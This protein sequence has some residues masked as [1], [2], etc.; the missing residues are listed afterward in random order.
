MDISKEDFRFEENQDNETEQIVT[1]TMSYLK[2]T[3]KRFVSNKVALT[4]LVILSIVIFFCIFGPVI[5][6]YD[7]EEINM[8]IKNQAPDA[9][10]W[11]GTDQLGRDLFARVWRGGRVSIMIGVFGALITAVVGCVY[12]GISAY[13]GGVVDMVMMRIVEIISSVPNLLV[14][15]LICMVFDSKGIGT[16]MFAMLVTGWCGLA[17]LVRSQMLQISS[18]EY[19]LAA[20]QM[21][22]SSMKIVLSHLIPNCMSTIIVNLTFR[23]PGLIFNEAFL[24]YIGLGVQS[25]DTSWGA[26]ASAASSV[27]M[28]HPYQL[29]FPTFMIAIVMLSFILIGDGLRDAMDPKL[30]R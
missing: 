18:S 10:H 25:P 8:S 16:L 9:Q 22:V 28:F 13:F 11:F 26:L 30:W 2:V 20:R 27:Y 21:G 15:I 3:M 12:G 1:P 17:R 14:V 5:C 23:I 19:V 4:A 7:Y 6:G 29:F 24:S